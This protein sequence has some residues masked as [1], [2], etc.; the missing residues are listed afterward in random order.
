MQ[1][2][3]IRPVFPGLVTNGVGERFNRTLVEVVRSMSAH[4]ELPKSFWAEALAIAI[5]LRN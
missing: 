5:Y 4:S 3:H 2:V 1:N